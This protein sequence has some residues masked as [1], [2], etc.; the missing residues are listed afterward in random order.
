ML[1]SLIVRDF[2]SFIGRHEF[3]I[4]PITI[5]LG[6]NSSGKSTITRLI[7]LMQQS[8][9][10][11]TSAPILW[12]GATVDF[13]SV[14]GVRPRQ[15]VGSTIGLGFSVVATD[16]M[17]RHLSMRRAGGMRGRVELDERIITYETNLSEHLDRATE[18]ER[19]RLS[20]I[21]IKIN[22][23]TIELELDGTGRVTR[24][25][26]NE[27][28]YSNEV[29]KSETRLDTQAFFPFTRT[30]KLSD[31]ETEYSHTSVD[32]I[33]EQKVSIVNL[34]VH[35]TTSDQTKRLLA[36]RLSYAPKATFERFLSEGSVG[37][38]WF[39]QQVKWTLQY[40]PERI[41]RL[42]HLTLLTYLGTI[43]SVIGNHVMGEFGR[44]SYVGPMRAAGE[45]YYR[46]KELAVD[47]LDPKGENFAMYVMSLGESERRRLSEIFQE[48]FGFSIKATRDGGHASLMLSESGADEW[49]NLADMGFG[50]SQILPVIAQIH[51]TPRLHRYLRPSGMVVRDEESP[52]LMAVEQPE[53]HLHPAFQAKIADLFCNSLRRNVS[54]AH[55]APTLTSN[56]FVVETHSEALVNRLSEL[57]SSG[58]IGPDDAV[59]YIFEKEDGSNQTSVRRV[60]FSRSGEIEK[61]P[62]GFFRY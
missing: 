16:E 51:A 20:G 5:L 2:R 34:L 47:R 7:P 23:D 60:D 39:Q 10:Q 38:D 33:D 27:I 28:D 48:S 45:R 29:T 55:D 37:T 8:F 42:R 14:A 18:Y 56:C 35:G 6:R 32:Y 13:G 36:L 50:F 3:D 24:C 40:V 1:K 57:V 52:W 21:T 53:L 19:T 15:K 46:W 30:K 11:R 62:Y 41:E 59:I 12:N 49:F 54:S 4:R 61:W 43:I 26:I 31:F 44:S 9:E 22:G 17:R 58:Q 25:T